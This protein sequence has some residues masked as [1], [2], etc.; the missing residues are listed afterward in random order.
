MR[1]YH[2]LREPDIRFYKNNNANF[3]FGSAAQ[4]H[5]TRTDH[6]LD[7]ALTSTQNGV[8]C[9]MPAAPPRKNSTSTGAIAS[10]ETSC[11]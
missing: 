3:E 11:V 9:Y 5:L 4:L 8:C 1:T 7:I 2:L 6:A 10:D